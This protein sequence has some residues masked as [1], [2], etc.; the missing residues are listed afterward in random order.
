[1]KKI[2]I[3]AA[4]FAIAAQAQAAELCSGSLVVIR[5]SKITSNMAAF[6]E[7]VKAQAAW[8]ASHNLADKIVFAPVVTEGKDGK[9]DAFSTTEAMTLHYYPE[10]KLEVAHDDAWK[11]FVA[12]FRASS[13]I[14]S[15]HIACLP[16]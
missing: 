9:A 7:A 16:K 14:T 10:K 11:D 4:F 15:E 1:M 5:S 6:E 2:V 13:E 8:Y 12:K 3:A